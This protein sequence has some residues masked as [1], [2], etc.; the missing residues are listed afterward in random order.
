VRPII[1]RALLLR[2]TRFFLLWLVLF[3]ALL[4]R[5]PAATVF[6][7]WTNIF[8]LEGTNVEWLFVTA[9]VLGAV[10][11]YDLWCHYLCPVGA[12]M[13]IVLRVRTWLNDGF[14]RVFSR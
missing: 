9:V 1:K 13:D 5:K 8:S 7:P 12:T 4:V 3:L 6:E 10:F 14:N 11:V 2:N